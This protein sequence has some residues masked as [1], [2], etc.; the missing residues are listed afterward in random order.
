MKKILALALASVMF[1]AVASSPVY[2][3][4]GIGLDTGNNNLAMS[5][6]IG[7]M[8]MKYFGIEGGMTGTSNYYL[9]DGAVKGVLPLGVVDLYGKL[10]MGINDYT[11]GG[12][13]STSMG[14]L[15]GGGVAFHVAPSWQLHVEDYTVS[16]SNP[17]FLMFGAQFNF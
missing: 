10:G 3:D 1:T 9:F 15:Y 5:G 12:N 13:N 4:G 2:V 11:G 6:N 16:G 7:Y 14:L 8:F 17:N